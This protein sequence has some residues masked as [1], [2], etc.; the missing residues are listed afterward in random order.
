M[1]KNSMVNWLRILLVIAVFIVLALCI[2]VIPSLGNEAAISN[3]EYAYLKIPVMVFIYFTALPFL[4]VLLLANNICGEIMKDNSF[5]DK[6][7]TLLIEISILAFSEVAL[8][9]IGAIVL[10]FLNALHPGILIIILLIIFIASAVSIF[11]AVL[12]RL[13]KKAVIIKS[14]NDLT[15]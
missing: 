4:T 15:V 9:L 13:V 5:S 6:N 12:S 10:F 14:E 3:P 7:V 1:K 8:Y 11:A 2:F